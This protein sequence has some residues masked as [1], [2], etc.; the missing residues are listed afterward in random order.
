MIPI[1]SSY[2]YFHL[3]FI[4]LLWETSVV[5][6]ISKYSLVTLYFR[7]CV[8]PLQFWIINLLGRICRIEIV[9]FQ[10]SNTLLHALLAFKVS[11]EKICCYFDGFTFICS[12]LFSN[13][14]CL[15]Y[16]CL[17]LYENF[18]LYYTMKRLYFG[19]VYLM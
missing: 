7:R 8:F 13:S 16:F 12:F 5:W 9:F 4:E 17:I 2:V 18:S 14:Y 11:V 1:L 3:L 6:F 19:H 10:C 15:Q